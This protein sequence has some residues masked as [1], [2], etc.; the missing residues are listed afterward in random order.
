MSSCVAEPMLDSVSHIFLLKFLSPIIFLCDRGGVFFFFVVASAARTGFGT[1]TL[2]GVCEMAF[3]ENKIRF[4]SSSPDEFSF[5][6]SVVPC[7]DFSD[8]SVEA[9]FEFLMSRSGFESSSGLKRSNAGGWTNSGIVVKSSSRTVI[10]ESD[11]RRIMFGSKRESPLGLKGRVLMVSRLHRE[12]DL[13]K[14]G[15]VSLKSL[16][17]LTSSSISSERNAGQEFARVK[18]GAE[19]ALAGPKLDSDVLMDGCNPLPNRNRDRDSSSS[20]NS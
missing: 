1:T 13:K 3:V 16:K 4:G 12:C 11:L 18:I 5:C 2:E 10:T 14:S 7:S 6:E 15:R 9:F 17:S 19:I 20:L 8:W